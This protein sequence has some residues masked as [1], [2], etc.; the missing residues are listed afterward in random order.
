MIHSLN[1]TIF[2]Y[3]TSIFK[4]FIMINFSKILILILSIQ[5]CSAQN[6]DIDWLKKI[7]NNRNKN[8]DKPLN[9]LSNTV[10]PA[11][12]VLP[13]GELGIAYAKRDKQ[14]RANAIHSTVSLIGSMGT[15]Y[16][17]KKT[18]QKPRP[19][20]TYLYIQNYYYDDDSTFPSGHTTAAFSTAT[21]LTLHYPKWYVAVPAYLY[22]G[23]IGYSR[24]HLGMHYPSDVAMGAGI[25]IASA[26]VTHKLQK[27]IK[28][29]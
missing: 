17:L 2:V 13:L 20:E 9:G 28:K 14:L 18:I 29:R 3:F 15:T 24:M 22:A 19:Y 11:S 26:F 6:T 1:S 21:S 23:A 4:E 25:G 7:N 5:F 10:Y 12:F 8:L 16:I 27:W